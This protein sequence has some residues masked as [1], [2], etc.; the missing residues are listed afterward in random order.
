[1]RRRNLFYGA[2]FKSRALLMVPLVG[3][4]FLC[5]HWEWEY[6]PGVWSL[7]LAMFLPGLLLRAWA[8]RHLRYRLHDEPKLATSGPY[9]YVRNPVYLANA[10]I[11][12]GLCVLCELVW[13]LPVTLV[14][15][16]L[17]YYL[18]VKFEEVR[19]AKRFGESYSRYC[20]R[21]PA[22]F[23][24]RARTPMA[25]SIPPVGWDRV[26]LAEWQCVLLL[27]G[28]VLKECFA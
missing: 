6:D 24:R 3:V 8:Q 5:K 18:A 13:M 15:A 9:A 17:V 10:L 21:V 25:A 4:L 27:A 7:G 28:A 22:W 26:A 20:S 14:W 16:G 1:V 23:P 11:L 2:A 19:L 12:G